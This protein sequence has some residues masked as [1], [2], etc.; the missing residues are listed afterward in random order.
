MKFNFTF[1]LIFCFLGYFHA[2]TSLQSP[3]EFLGYK[4]GTEFTRHHQVLDYF[5]HLADNSPKLSFSSYG[6]TNER[7]T[8]SY[9]VVSSEENL[10]KIEE[11]RTNHLKQAG[12]IEGDATSNIAVVWLSYNVHGNE[13]SSTEAAMVTAYELVTKHE[14]TL[15]NTIVIIDPSVNPDGRDRYVNWYNQVKATPYSP[16]QDAVEHNEPWPGGRPNHYLFDLNRDWMWATQVETQ[17]R[18]KLYNQWMPHVHVDFH[19]QGINSPYYFAPAAEPFHEVITDFQKEFQTKIGKNNAKAFDENAWSYFTR[20]RF[21]LFYPS[22]GDTYPTYNGAIGMTYE[23]AGNGQAGLGINTDED[24]ELTLVDR[25][26][27][28]NISGL[29]TV[30]ISSE[31]ATELNSEFKTYFNHSPDFDHYVL[32]GDEQKLKVLSQLFDRHEYTYAYATDKSLK[33]KNTYSSAKTSFEAEHALVLPANQPKAKMLR[34]LFE[35]DPKL[36]TPLTYDITSWN[37]A[38]AHGVEVFKVSGK[39]NSKSEKDHSQPLQVEKETVGYISPWKSTTDAKFLAK[40]LQHEL[41]VRATNKP[42]K[43][44]GKSYDRGSLIITKTNNKQA[45]FDSLVVATANEFKIDLKATKTS[46]SDSGTD[47]GSPDVKKIHPQRIAILRGKGTSSLS[48]GSL[49]YFFEQELNYPLISIAT[50]DFNKIDLKNYDVLVLPNGRYSSIVDKKGLEA[51]T[52]W[53]KGGGKVIAIANALSTFEGKKGFGLEKV[54]T[55]KDSTQVNLTP[56]AELEKERTKD[57]IT[58]AIF[59]IKVDNTHPLGFG[60]GDEYATLKTS[61]T[62]YQYLQKGYNVGYLDDSS[63]RLSGFV[64]EKASEKIAKSLVFGEQRLG[65]GSLIYMVDDVMFRSFWENGKLF[66]VN[67]LFMVNNRSQKFR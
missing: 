37:L 6:K 56:Y 64:G 28:H 61:S 66:F 32:A 58:G 45:D 13:A 48:Y 55:E 63:Q 9:A 22:Y 36:K 20:E 5:N 49:W 17:Q 29:S 26:Q 21:D 54:K 46:F 44:E 30:E 31:F 57:N 27:H 11:I 59:N 3:E 18:L 25:V 23:Q 50:D 19:E 42:F 1:V 34:V 12:L 60:Y 14:E 7:R 15:Q 8:L 4:I 2:Q 62:A 35:A 33:G 24:Y 16:Y 51:L 10:S 52:N 67:A 47:F 53:I 39:V 41:D 40:L 38:L 43:I 65:R